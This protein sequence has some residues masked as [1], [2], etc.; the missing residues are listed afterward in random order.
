M[1]RI[2]LVFTKSKKFFP[3]FSWALMLYTKKPYSHIARKL[4]T[5]HEYP[6]Y[7]Q[8][9]EGKVNYE[10]EP[11]FL[12]KNQVISKLAFLVP[13]VFYEEMAKRSWEQAGSPYGTLQN[14]GT[15]LVDVLKNFNIL[16]KNPIE[17]GKVCSELI[18]TTILKPMFPDLEYDENSIKPHHIEQ[19][20]HKKALEGKLTLI[21]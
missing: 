6:S 21:D 10:Y 13:E 2:E 20:I 4:Y 5:S 1:K 16:V 17:K 12:K 14:L 11:F 8:A 19:I 18:Y 7:F 15:L 3:I 9:S